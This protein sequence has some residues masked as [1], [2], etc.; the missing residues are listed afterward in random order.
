MC[1]FPQ[2]I[3]ENF[4]TIKML[5][6]KEYK[7]PYLF[8]IGEKLLKLYQLMRKLIF[9]TALYIYTIL[10]NIF[11]HYIPNKVVKCSHRGPQRITK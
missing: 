2:V 3:L 1:P 9:L 11:L 8:L 7:N 5:M 10:Y 6:L 4:E